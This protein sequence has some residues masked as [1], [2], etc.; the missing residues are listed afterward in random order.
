MKTLF[1]TVTN[2]IKAVKLLSDPRFSKMLEKEIKETTYGKETFHHKHYIVQ[3][4]H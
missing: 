4:M 1:N 2:T 3:V